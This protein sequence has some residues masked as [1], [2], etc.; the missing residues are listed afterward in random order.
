MSPMSETKD[1]EYPPPIVN[2]GELGTI[3]TYLEFLI[4]YLSLFLKHIILAPM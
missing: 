2:L 1:G 4:V 3:I